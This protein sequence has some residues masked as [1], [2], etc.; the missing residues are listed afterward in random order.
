MALAFT[1]LGKADQTGDELLCDDESAPVIKPI[2]AGK[3]SVKPR[4]NDD[5]ADAVHFLE[6]VLRDL[7]NL[8]AQTEN[9]ALRPYVD[10]R[11]AALIRRI[12]DIEAAQKGNHGVTPDV[13]LEL[14]KLHDSLRS[15]A[16]D[17]DQRFKVV[18]DRI[19]ERSKAATMHRDQ[20]QTQVN[21][22]IAVCIDDLKKANSVLEWVVSKQN[23]QSVVAN[24]LERKHDEMAGE[25]KQFEDEI[26]DEWKTLSRQQHNLALQVELL[27]HERRLARRPLWKRISSA[28]LRR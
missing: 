11:L 8:V 17:N 16:T 12:G 28:L 23:A 27:L 26:R 3:P 10:E 9:V 20:L 13:A 24:G 1:S 19:A 5:I 15:L 25:V 14:N 7:T 22:R 21:D 18:N 6:G 2:S 4:L